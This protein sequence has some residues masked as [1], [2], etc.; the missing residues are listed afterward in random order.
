MLSPAKALSQL[1]KVRFDVKSSRH[2]RSVVRRCG[3]TGGLLAAQREQPP[4]LATYLAGEHGFRQRR[5]QVVD[6]DRPFLSIISEI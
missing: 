4:Q 5:N 1:P 2:V 3:R 6:M